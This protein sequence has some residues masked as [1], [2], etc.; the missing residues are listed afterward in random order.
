MSSSSLHWLSLV[1]TI[2][3]QTINGPNSDFAV[4]SSQLKDIKH[5]SQVQ[6]NML[7]FASDAGKLFGCFS[8][9]AVIHLAL[10]VITIATGVCAVVGSIGPAASS[11][12]SQHL[13]LSWQFSCFLL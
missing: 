3:L 8:G 2:W 4:Y 11:L 10:F 6:L 1:A 5:F 12:S 7:A 9:I 13:M